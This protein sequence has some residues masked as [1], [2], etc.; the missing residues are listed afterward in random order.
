MLKWIGAGLVLCL[1]AA[2]CGPS[3]AVEIQSSNL[4]PL[5]ICYGHYIARHRGQAPPSESEFKAFIK[6]LEPSLLETLGAKDADSI[7]VSSRMPRV[8][9]T[10]A[11]FTRT[12][13]CRQ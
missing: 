3:T 7:F 2:G 10:P 11:N 9:Q 8:S 6:T 12:I 5:S 13:E 1:L 4:K